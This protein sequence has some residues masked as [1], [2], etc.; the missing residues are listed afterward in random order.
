[1]GRLGL[2]MYLG[3]GKPVLMC[4]GRS[5]LLQEVRFMRRILTAD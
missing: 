2:S 5:P 4:D 3:G 1:M